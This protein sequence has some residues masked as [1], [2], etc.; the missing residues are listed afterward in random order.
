MMKY[1][2]NWRTAKIWHFM[3][4]VKEC[5]SSTFVPIELSSEN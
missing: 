4:T 2:K 1:L 5:T 3:P